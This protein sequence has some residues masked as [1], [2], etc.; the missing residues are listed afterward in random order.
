M[1]ASAAAVG[2][3]S[4][5][6]AVNIDFLEK[7][8]AIPSVTA[9]IPEVNKASRCMKDYLSRRGIHCTIETM[10]DGREVLYAATSPGKR[11]DFVFSVHLDVVPPGRPQHFTLKRDGDRIEGRGVRDCKGN[12]VVVA[13]ILCELVGKNVSVGCVFGPDEE[14]GGAG[15]RWTVQEKGY[16]PNKMA[17]VVDAGYGKIYYAHKGQ[18]YI[19]ITAKG[20][21]GHSSRPWNCD[22]SITKLMQAYVKIREIWDRRHPIPEDKWSDVMVP[23]FVKADS[24]AL[25]LV[26][27]EVELIL[28]LRSV[29]PCAKDELAELAREVSGCEVEI[30]RS[31]PPVITDPNHPLLNKLR[32]VMS[33]SMGKDIGLDRMLAATDARWFV[34]CGVPIAMIGAYG[35]GSHAIEEYQTISSLEEMEAYLIK[36]LLQASEGR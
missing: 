36:F 34:G 17:I 14:I 32:F 7:L 30:M 1:I 31:S 19:R 18:N 35:G 12:A 22:D 33:E 5:V 27:G 25:N 23:T 9:D 6:Y 26:P 16:K 11:H 13:E 10:D 15:T 21:S 2:I 4:G 29:N 28:N 8:I 24:G 3:S 20:R